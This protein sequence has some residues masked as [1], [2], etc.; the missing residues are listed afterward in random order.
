[1]SLVVLGSLRKSSVRALLS[2][3]G[4]IGDLREPWRVAH[5]LSEAFLLVVCGTSATAMT[6]MLSQPGAKRI[7]LRAIF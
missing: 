7:S 1:M 6:I 4:E 3:L 2:H 5:P